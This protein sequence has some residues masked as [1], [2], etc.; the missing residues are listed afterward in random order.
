MSRMTRDQERWNT[1]W[2]RGDMIAVAAEAPVATR[3]AFI[4][5][6]Y[7]HVA[8]AVLAFTA[9][10]AGLMQLPMIDDIV[11]MMSSRGAWLVL[12]LAFTGVAYGADRL[13]RS[14]AS[15]GLQYLGLALYVLLEAAIFTPMIYFASRFGP[16]NVLLTAAGATGALF[17]GLTATVFLTKADF[18]FLRIVL[19]LGAVAATVAVVASLLLGFSLGVWF[20]VAM[21]FLASAYIA[22]DTSNILHHYRT[23]QHV[24]A[25]LALFASVM[26]LFW[27]V[28][29]LFM[30]RRD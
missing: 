16:P 1:P 10:T 12:M 21:I 24:A 20:T 25:S 14:E 6:T 17:L 29:R 15:S 4:R 5:R 23:D 13:A 7:L 9:I 28:L 8:G 30:Q 19:L 27:Y 18:S 22:Y 11:R 2:T 26:L 3:V